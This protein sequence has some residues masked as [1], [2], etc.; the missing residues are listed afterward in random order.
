MFTEATGECSDGTVVGEGMFTEPFHFRCYR[1][2]PC[3]TDVGKLS[4]HQTRCAHGY[5]GPGT[6]PS[7]QQESSLLACLSFARLPVSAPTAIAFTLYLTLLYSW[8]ASRTLATD[9]LGE[10]PFLDGGV[11]DA[12]MRSSM[13]LS[14]R[15][16]SGT[17]VPAPITPMNFENLKYLNHGS[18]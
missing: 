10:T 7:L 5:M 6:T 11:K 1:V 8:L 15:L 2:C 4:K 18:P 13:S 14:F 9:R 17:S 12:G 16:G 3:T